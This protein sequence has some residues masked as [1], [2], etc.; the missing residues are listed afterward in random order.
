MDEKNNP[1]DDNGDDILV[2]N[3]LGKNVCEFQKTVGN[4]KMIA[5]LERTFAI[6]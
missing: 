4:S 3:G 2:T 6:P 1:I 5:I